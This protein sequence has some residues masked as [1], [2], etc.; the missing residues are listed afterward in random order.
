MTDE[1]GMRHFWFPIL[2]SRFSF[3]NF[4]NLTSYV[5]SL[6]SRF[7][8]PHPNL[9]SHVSYLLSPISL[10]VIRFILQDRKSPIQL[11]HKKYPDHLVGKG[12]F[13]K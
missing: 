10:M 11:F 2:P 5:L 12:H 1:K 9:I 8:L 4:F 3:P 7:L 6:A 13:G